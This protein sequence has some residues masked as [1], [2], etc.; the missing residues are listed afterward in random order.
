[1]AATNT[2]TSAAP[3]LSHDEA[4]WLS[5]CP[6]G[7]SRSLTKTVGQISQTFTVDKRYAPAPMPWLYGPHGTEFMPGDVICS[8]EGTGASPVRRLTITSP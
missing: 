3:L 6:A 8:G 4:E 7:Q 1:M 2:A 5:G